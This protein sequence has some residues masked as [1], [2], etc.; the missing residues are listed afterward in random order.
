MMRGHLQRAAHFQILHGRPWGS[1]LA[2]TLKEQFAFG[3]IS[4]TKAQ[5]YALAAVQD[6]ELE[7]FARRGS[8]GELEQL[9]RIGASGRYPNHCHRELLDIV[10]GPDAPPP[11]IFRLPQKRM[12]GL[13]HPLADTHHTMQNPCDVI[14]K[15]HSAY[16]KGFARRFLGTDDP[17]S[18]PRIL[19][20]F[21]NIVPNHDPRKQSLKRHYRSRFATEAEMWRN[22]VPISIHGDG[23]PVASQSCEAISLSGILGRPL[24]TID[25]KILV[26]GMLSSCQGASTKTDFWDAVMW[27]LI[28]LTEGRWPR[29][30]EHG[31]EYVDG[32]EAVRAGTTFAGGLVF[33][34]WMVK[35]DLDWFANGLHLE[36]CNSKGA[37]CVWCKANTIEALDEWAIAFDHRCL[38]WNDISAT[39]AWRDTVWADEDAWRIWR[40]CS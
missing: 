31:V 12:K 11:K 36:N 24:A 23:V 39:A 10:L 1:K 37:M 25:A 9:A 5:M 7:E 30:D 32:D 14:G 16:P 20:E 3:L 29:E 2:Q 35:G 26:S 18:A 38:P 34:I 21:W 28:A 27:A 13:M 15:L 6:H 33:A 4:A 17:A 22:I 40:G 8:P 19:S